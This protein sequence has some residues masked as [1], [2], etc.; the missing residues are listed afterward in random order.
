[1]KPIDEKNKELEKEVKRLKELLRK[2]YNIF[3]KLSVLLLFLISSV[4][5]FGQDNMMLDDMLIDRDIST[6]V[7][8]L[9]KYIG[10]VEL[11]LGI[12]SHKISDYINKNRLYELDEI[13]DKT[14]KKLKL[15]KEKVLEHITLYKVYNTITE[16]DIRTFYKM[17]KDEPKLFKEYDDNT[18]MG[19]KTYFYKDSG[20][21]VA[22]T[23]VII[24]KK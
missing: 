20:M 6:Y 24:S 9:R 8:N 14:V 3:K 15:K 7:N 18:V 2:K 17:I 19:V 11:P 23:T 16:Y 10:M 5:S 22:K 12:E 4:S 21:I 13:T 1:M